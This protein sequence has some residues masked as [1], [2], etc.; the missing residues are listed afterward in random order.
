MHVYVLFAYPSKASFTH[1]VFEAFTRGLGEAGHTFEIGD[2][3]EMNFRTDMDLE[4]YTRESSLDTGG[5]IPEDVK[6]E[7]AK[8]ARADALAFRLS[9]LVEQLPGLTEKE[10]K[11]V[12]GEC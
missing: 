2:L 3:Y 1:E 7:Q 6:A 5:P 8:I 12:E 4:H 10:I 11:I 9:R